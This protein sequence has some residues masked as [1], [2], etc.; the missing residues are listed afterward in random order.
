LSAA[1]PETAAF[2]RGVDE[3][4]GEGVSQNR[5]RRASLPMAGSKIEVVVKIRNSSACKISEAQSGPVAS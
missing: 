4:A 1:L 5:S 3:A 2:E